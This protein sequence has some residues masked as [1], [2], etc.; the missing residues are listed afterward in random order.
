MSLTRRLSTRCSEFRHM[1]GSGILYS[2]LAVL[3]VDVSSFSPLE[4]KSVPSQ[5]L[6]ASCIPRSTA[7][8][9]SP[10]NRIIATSLRASCEDKPGSP[11][12]NLAA[13]FPWIYILNVRSYGADFCRSTSASIHLLSDPPP[14]LSQLLCPMFAEIDSLSQVF[15]VLSV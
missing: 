3:A 11:L 1:S 13:S 4:S 7:R 9:V 2:D 6:F 5:E 15:L 14:Q 8:R 10:A 12:N